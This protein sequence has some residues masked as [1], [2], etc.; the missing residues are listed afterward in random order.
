VPPKETIKHVHEFLQLMTVMTGDHRYEEAYE[1]PGRRPSNMC[2]V[3]E[4]AERKGREQ[5]LEQGLEQGRIKATIKTLNRYVRRKLPIDSQ[6][7]ADIAVDNDL[8]VERV[9]E[10][11]KENNVVLPC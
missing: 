1:T 11:A 10:I 3:M 2:E 4:A 5:G 7:L 9:R 6:V 8:T